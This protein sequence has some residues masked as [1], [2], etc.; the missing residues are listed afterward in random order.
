[1]HHLRIVTPT[2]AMRRLP[3]P[4]RRKVVTKV[5]WSDLESQSYIVGKGVTLFVGFYTFL[6]WMYY[7]NLRERVEDDDKSKK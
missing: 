5:S 3:P 2:L 4:I 7:K 1:M 6:Q